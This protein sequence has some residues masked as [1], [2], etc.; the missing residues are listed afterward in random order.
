MELSSDQVV[1]APGEVPATV[2]SAGREGA[3]RPVEATQEEAK[4]RGQAK[5]TGRRERK[6]KSWDNQPMFIEEE[7][8]TEDLRAAWIGYAPSV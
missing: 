2:S 6:E 1:S 4:R 5:D 7:P 3:Q 8:W